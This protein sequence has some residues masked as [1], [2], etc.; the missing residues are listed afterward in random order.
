MFEGITQRLKENAEAKKKREEELR[1]I[2]ILAKEA[3]L[4]QKEE[5]T[6]ATAILKEKDRGKKDREFIENG[7]VW[8]AVSKGMENLS[9][10]IESN[11]KTSSEKGIKANKAKP[12]PT[13]GEKIEN[14]SLGDY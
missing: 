9:K 14:F 2:N 3:A 10:N 8:G 1:R 11:T 5:E 12:E 4:K 13:I 7:G 6:I